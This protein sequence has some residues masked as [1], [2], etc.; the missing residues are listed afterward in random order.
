MRSYLVIF[1]TALAILLLTPAV[2]GLAAIQLSREQGDSLARKIE[3]INRNAA[4]QPV[5]PKRTPITESE[6][7]SYLAFNVKDQ[8]PRGLANPEIRMIGELAGRVYVDM[9]EFKRGR[10]SGGVMDPLSYVSGQVPLTA[11]GT[12]R[13]RD[14][15]GQFQLIS[16]EIHGV[17]LPKQIVQ[18]LVSYFSRTPDRPNGFNM[19]EPFV[20]PAKVREVTV[21]SGEG[22]ISQ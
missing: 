10:S 17:P 20:L 4:A 8:I 14:G 3:D 16:A 22:M 7:N 19:D 2:V 11:R 5:R 13:T 21:N 6:I 9:D 1:R 12:L 18:E 15:K